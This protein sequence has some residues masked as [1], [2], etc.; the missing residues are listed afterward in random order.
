MIWC[1]RKRYSILTPSL[2]LSLY[3]PPCTSVSSYFSRSS[4][5]LC[6]LSHTAAIQKHVQDHLGFHHLFLL[7][8][9]SRLLYPSL[10]SV[11][12]QKVHTHPH[13]GLLFP[14]VPGPLQH[15]DTRT[16]SKQLGGNTSGA[17][18]LQSDRFFS[19]P[20]PPSLLTPLGTVQA[21]KPSS[22]HTC[23]GS[24]SQAIADKLQ[25]RQPS[26][27]TAHTHTHTLVCYKHSLKSQCKGRI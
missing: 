25:T 22:F 3:Q 27:F 26:P 2:S 9:L 21:F 16:T 4:P 24:L 17:Y 23:R 11:L 8:F 15:L 7:L 1:W 13:K 12:A 19:P 14:A 5:F 18:C 20:S 10:L 6:A